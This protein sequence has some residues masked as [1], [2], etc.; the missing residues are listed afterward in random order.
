[1]RFPRLG[2]HSIAITLL[3][4]LVTV[5]ISAQTIRGVVVVAESAKAY[6]KPVLSVI[7]TGC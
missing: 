7:S 3:G 5:P 1:M 2:G 6:R 4:L